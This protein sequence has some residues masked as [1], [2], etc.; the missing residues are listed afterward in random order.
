MV[1]PA[2]L[3]C[4]VGYAFAPA[5]MAANAVTNRLRGS[6]ARPDPRTRVP[7]DTRRGLDDECYRPAG[8]IAWRT[9]PNGVGMGPLT[10]T[11]TLVIPAVI[12]IDRLPDC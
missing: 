4:D 11:A 10:S 9:T 2:A 3:I 8:Q 6:T 1:R 5:L 7:A 12:F